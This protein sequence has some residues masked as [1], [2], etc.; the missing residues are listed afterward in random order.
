MAREAGLEGTWPGETIL[1]CTDWPLHCPKCDSNWFRVVDIDKADLWGARCSCGQRGTFPKQ[2]P[3]MRGL[4]RKRLN[5]GKPRLP[6]KR[7][8]R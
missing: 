4:I 7:R 1:D 5:L 8:C 2:D 6:R 3:L